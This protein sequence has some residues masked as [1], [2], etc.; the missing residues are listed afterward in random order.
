MMYSF[1]LSTFI[2]LCVFVFSGTSTA[3]PVVARHGD[4]HSYHQGE[5]TYYDTE[6]NNGA[7]GWFN[8]DYE[9]VLAI[10]QSMWDETRDGNG[11]STACG[12]G[13]TLRHNGHYVDAVVV[14][15][16]PE[17]EHGSVDLSPSAFEA[18]DQKDAGRIWIDWWFH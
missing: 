9:H 13:V 7:C 6:R 16:C 10:S 1:T 4:E 11:R 15:L 2:T 8:H 14:D 18:L 12:R 17:C 5:A 3:A